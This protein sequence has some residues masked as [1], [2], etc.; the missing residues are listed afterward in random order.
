MVMRW[1]LCS[2][3]SKKMLDAFKQAL[4]SS[5]GVPLLI[6]GRFCLKLPAKSTTIPPMICRLPLISLIVR[7][8]AS[9]ALLWDMALAV[10]LAGAAPPVSPRL[11]YFPSTRP[12]GRNGVFTRS[13]DRGAP[14]ATEN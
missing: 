9:I 10:V 8:R 14:T 6:T 2:K 7:S 11:I 3:Q 13:I 5:A 4:I 12:P 1:N